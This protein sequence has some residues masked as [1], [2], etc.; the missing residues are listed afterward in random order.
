MSKKPIH[1][2]FLC[3]HNP[4]R[5]ILAEALN[6]LALQVLE[7]AGISIQGLGSKSCDKF[8]KP[9]AP[10]PVRLDLLV[11]LPPDRLGKLRLNATARELANKN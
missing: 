11:S 6:P 7:H 4:A 1:V 5:S 10:R 3:T 2:L 8:G 9:D